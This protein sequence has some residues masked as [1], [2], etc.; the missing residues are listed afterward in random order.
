MS[1]DDTVQVSRDL[2]GALIKAAEHAAMD[3]AAWRAVEAGRAIL[4]ASKSRHPLQPG[5]RV[6]SIKGEIDYDERGEE[7]YTP[8]GSV[9]EVLAVDGLIG[10][11]GEV[12]VSVYHVGFPVTC[13]I[14]RLSPRE[15]DDA[16]RYR[17]V[18][19]QEAGQ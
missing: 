1:A 4:H 14:V 6:V 10:G 13:A 17:V 18:S 15:V 12:V 5:T 11:G 2:L 3:E 16:A 8:Q 7:R 9:G 19:D